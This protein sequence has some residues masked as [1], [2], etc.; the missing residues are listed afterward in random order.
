MCIYLNYKEQYFFLRKVNLGRKINSCY[1]FLKLI[2]FMYTFPNTD[3]EDFV[4]SAQIFKQRELWTWGKVKVSVGRRP[5]E[6]KDNYG[7]KEQ[8]VI[9][10]YT[11]F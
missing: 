3:K 8:M 1:V 10:P 5:I 7:E 4:E 6:W 9:F 2:H 11:F